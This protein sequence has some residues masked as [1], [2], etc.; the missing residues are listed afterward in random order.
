MTYTWNKKK[1]TKKLATWKN[2]NK[3]KNSWRL[4]SSIQPCAPTHMEKLGND[5]VQK[6][7]FKKKTKAWKGQNPYVLTHIEDLHWKH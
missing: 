7:N 4:Q 6:L 3:N 5:I 2:K 1:M